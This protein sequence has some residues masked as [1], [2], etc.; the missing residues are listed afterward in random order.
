MEHGFYL[1]SKE[2]GTSANSSGMGADTSGND[3]HFAASNLA[4]ID[5]TADTPTNNF[6]TL[7]FTKLEPILLCLKVI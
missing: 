1:E 2:T 6:A 4:A 3:N 5:V 7:N